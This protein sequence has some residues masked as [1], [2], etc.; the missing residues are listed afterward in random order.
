MIGLYNTDV[1]A[2]ARASPGGVIDIDFLTGTV[3]AGTPSR[4][5][6]D[7][8]ALYPDAGE[9]LCQRHQLPESAF[10]QLTARYWSKLL[11]RRYLVTVM[12]RD[13]R[14]AIDHYVG[15]SGRRPKM[16]YPL[17]RVRRATQVAEG[18]APRG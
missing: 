4:A 10:W 11:E 17:G 15:I 12:N 14:L 13:G 1:F 18:A 9:S 2:E 3:L 7:A 16:L 8:T 6:S 5:F